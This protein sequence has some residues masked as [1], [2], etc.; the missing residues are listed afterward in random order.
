MLPQGQN[1]RQTSHYVWIREGHIE[2]VGFKTIIRR[3]ENARH[4]KPPPTCP[5]INQQ[6][7]RADKNTGTAPLPL[8]LGAVSAPGLL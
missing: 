7:Q 1:P 2:R 3:L 8:F 4:R 5:F 6:C